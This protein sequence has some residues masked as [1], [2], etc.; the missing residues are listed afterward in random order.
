MTWSRS[1]PDFKAESYSRDF[2]ATFDGGVTWRGSA[3][4]GPATPAGTVGAGTVD[5]EEMVV[6]AVSSCHMLFFLALASRK[7]LVIDRYEDDAIG[8]L[9]A[10]DGATWLTR[11][12]LRPRVTWGGAPPDK[13]VV[14]EL[15]HGAHK[16]CYIANSLKG[17]VVVDP[18]EG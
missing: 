7:G 4:S 9:E 13:A 18:A 12:T 1:S 14:D 5:P 11:I 15:H 17:E 16:R 3:A 10:K 2:D 6:A 8:V